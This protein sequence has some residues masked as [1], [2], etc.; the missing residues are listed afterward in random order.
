MKEIYPNA[1][2]QEN[3]DIEAYKAHQKEYKD[4]INKLQEE[5]KNDLFQ[6]Y[7]VKNNPKSDLLFYKVKD[8]RVDYSEIYDL[9][10]DLVE[11]IEELK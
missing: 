6:A 5:F 8:M 11:L 1:V 2:I 9:F 7:G 3:L 10:G 4:E